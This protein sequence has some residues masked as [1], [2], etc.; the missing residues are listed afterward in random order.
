MRIASGAE[1]EIRL[2]IILGEYE[3]GDNKLKR[4]LE[5]DTNEKRGPSESC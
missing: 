2:F 5:Y 1:D 4:L 3:Q